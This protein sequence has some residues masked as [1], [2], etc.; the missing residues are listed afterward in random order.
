MWKY[1]STDNLYPEYDSLYHSADELYHHG[2]LGMRWGHRKAKSDGFISNIQKKRLQKKEE[3][4]AKRAFKEQ[5]MIKSNDKRVKTYGKNTVKNMNRLSMV[6][7][8][9]GANIVSRIIANVGAEKLRSMSKKSKYGVAGKT[10]GMASLASIGAVNLY[11]LN[12]I[13]KLHKDNKLANDY[14][15]RKYKKRLAQK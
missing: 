13:R 3:K 15:Y 6:G 1:N 14:D 11:A 7:Q 4:H 5:Q 12:N 8:L 9:Y 2:I 10:I